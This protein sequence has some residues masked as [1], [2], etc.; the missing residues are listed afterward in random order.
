MSKNRI[1]VPAK[2][3]VAPTTKF[4]EF[5]QYENGRTRN[6]KFD[7]NALADFEQETGMGFAQ[8]MQ[9]RAVFG[10]ARALVWAGL[11]HEDRSLRIED[12]GDLLTQYLKDEEAKRGEHT[13]D[14]ILSVVIEAAVDQ[15]AFGRRV[16]EPATDDSDV[17][18]AAPA[19]GLVPNA[20]AS[21]PKK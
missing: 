1:S 18:D 5:S 21:G 19:G 14:A 16:E 4:T 11:K 3:P 10:S 13:I 20:P 8:L 6:L 9:K 7:V 15:G 17:V 12:I 2:K